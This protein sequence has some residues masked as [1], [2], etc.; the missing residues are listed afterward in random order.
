MPERRHCSVF[1]R[2]HEIESVPTLGM[3]LKTMKHENVNM[4]V[5]DLGGQYRFRDDWF[6][7]A[8]A[9]NVILFVVDVADKERI[10]E[11][12]KELHRLL[13]KKDLNG[14][15]L[16]VIGNKIDV[17]GHVT[18]AELVKGLRVLSLSLSLCVIFQAADLSYLLPQPSI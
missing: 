4:K 17:E 6:R 7:Y 16:L 12:K 10:P 5:W 15:P 9:C 2:E 11:A 8:L 18:K 13:E 3:N 14:L 1:Y